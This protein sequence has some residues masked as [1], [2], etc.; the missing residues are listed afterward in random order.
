MVETV[1]QFMRFPLECDGDIEPFYLFLLYL[2]VALDPAHADRVAHSSIRF[3]TA[4]VTTVPRDWIF[5]MCSR[6]R[7]M[8]LVIVLF[9]QEA[10][11]YKIQLRLCRSGMR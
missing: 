9:W 8:V 3:L 10:V 7:P 6:R 4:G 2:F 5:E 1:G 11:P